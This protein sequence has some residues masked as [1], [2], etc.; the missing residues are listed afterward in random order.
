MISHTLVKDVMMKTGAKTKD[1]IMKWTILNL[2][3]SGLERDTQR[4]D[5]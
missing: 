3:I 2:C 4:I 5:F 1:F